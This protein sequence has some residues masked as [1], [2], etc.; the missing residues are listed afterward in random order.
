VVTEYAFRPSEVTAKVNQVVIWSFEGAE[1]H[2]LFFGLRP[3][4]PPLRFLQGQY[5]VRYGAPQ[6]V[7]YSCA[8]HPEMTG[9]VIIEE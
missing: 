7:E 2:E 9:T 3:G 8:I 5:S 1:E 6:T 4:A